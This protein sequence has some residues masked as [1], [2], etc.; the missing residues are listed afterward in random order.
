MDDQTFIDS[1]FQS[2]QD[3]AGEVRTS[4]RKKSYLYIF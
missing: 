3:S 1:I 4:S 2:M